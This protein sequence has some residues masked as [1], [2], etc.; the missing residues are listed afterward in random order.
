MRRSVGHF[1]DR[2]LGGSISPLAAY[3]TDRAEVSDDELRELKR[4][5]EALSERRRRSR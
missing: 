4:A 1:V 5:V 2:A 3:L